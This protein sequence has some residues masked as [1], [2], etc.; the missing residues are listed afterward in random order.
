MA[1][2]IHFLDLWHVENPMRLAVTKPGDIH[3]SLNG[4]G[5]VGEVVAKIVL[6]LLAELA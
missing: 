3:Y 5:E 4:Q 2:G 6:Q 1:Y